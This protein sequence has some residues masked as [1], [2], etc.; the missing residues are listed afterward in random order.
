MPKKGNPRAHRRYRALRQR[1]LND[2]PLCRRCNAQGYTVTATELHHVIPISV[3]PEKLMDEDNLEPL[4]R[5][6]HSQTKNHSRKA[7][8]TLEGDL[9]SG[10]PY[11]IM[12]DLEGNP[13]NGKL[14]FGSAYRETRDVKVSSDGKGGFIMR[15]KE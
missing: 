9:I 14:K 4:C 8:A 1:I 7:G 12:D 3:A 5:E 6:C 13:E 10:F 11:K 2:E 15:V